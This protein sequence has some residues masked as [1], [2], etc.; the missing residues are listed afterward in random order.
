MPL[1]AADLAAAILTKRLIRL[2][3]RIE[4]SPQHSTGSE[5]KSTFYSWFPIGGQAAR[6]L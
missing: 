3:I 6:I 1:I 2:S 4:E 5:A